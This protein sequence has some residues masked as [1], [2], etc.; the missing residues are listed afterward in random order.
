MKSLIEEVGSDIH[1]LIH[2]TGGGQTKVLRFA[3]NMHVVKDNLFDPPAI[4]KLIQHESSASWKEMYEVFNMGHRLE[5]Y[6]P[7]V[8]A[9]NAIAISQSLDVDAK[10]VGHCVASK[11][12]QVSIITAE[13]TYSYQ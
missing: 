7:K 6:L 12:P 3:G 13:G 11:A 8:H 10:I 2:C 1:G 9:E 5:V 4:F